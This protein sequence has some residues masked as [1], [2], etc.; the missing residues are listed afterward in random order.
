MIGVVFANDDMLLR[1][2]MD[3]F[4]SLERSTDSVFGP[5]SIGAS[6]QAATA[7]RNRNFD[8]SIGYWH[9]GDV[10]S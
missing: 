10:H 1:M 3:F 9:L 8:I 6:S 4:G 2:M 7:T 5:H